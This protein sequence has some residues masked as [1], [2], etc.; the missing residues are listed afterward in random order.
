MS[1][2]GMLSIA[3][4]AVFGLQCNRSEAPVSA[5]HE[6]AHADTREHADGESSPQQ[7]MVRLPESVCDA[8]GIEV[9]EVGYRPCRSLLKAMGKVLA[10]QPQTA[11]VSHPFPGRVAEVH[12][13]VGEWV[14]KEQALITLESHEVGEAKSEFYKARADLELAQL[15]LAREKR[16]SESGIGI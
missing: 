10:P 1:K 13:S 6:H 16:L 14:E 4:L 9:E 8:V 3:L 2:E 7:G 11:I 5:P 15:N 12:V